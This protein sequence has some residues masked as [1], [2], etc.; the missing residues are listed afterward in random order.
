M[1]FPEP[2][3]PAIYRRYLQVLGV[4]Y[5]KPDVSFLFDITKA[6]LTK[7]PFENVS[8]LYYR[9]NNDLTGLPDFDKYLGGIEHYH[10]GGTCYANNYY[11][12]LL[13]KHLGFDVK[14]CGADM[15]QADV[16]L[17]NIVQV[18]E[19]EF[20]VDVGYAAPFLKPFPLNENR[21]IILDWGRDK[22]RLR[23]GD[24]HGRHRLEMYQEGVLKHGYLVNPAPRRIEEFVHV[25]A[26]SFRDQAT[27]MN[28]LLLVKF[29]ENWSLRLNNLSITETR[30]CHAECREIESR[31]SLPFVIQELFGIPSGIAAEALSTLGQFGDAWT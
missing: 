13:L 23:P 28:S 30:G 4:S 29:A 6:H 11:L 31:K 12:H 9:K 21:D 22:Y 2:G 19:R 25:I 17:V 15:S 7:I 3:D 20:L 10:F 5:K 1:I 8:K 27:F 16:H 18:E 24:P 26:D 14:L